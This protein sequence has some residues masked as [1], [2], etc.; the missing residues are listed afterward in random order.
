MRMM[1]PQ[2]DQASISQSFNQN[3]NIPEKK[4]MK[5]KEMQVP[6]QVSYTTGLFEMEEKTRMVEGMYPKRPCVACGTDNLKRSPISRKQWDI[7]QHFKKIEAY[8]EH[9]REF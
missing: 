7:N 5:T 4:T 8:V 9:R 3:G 1:S 6:K 2:I